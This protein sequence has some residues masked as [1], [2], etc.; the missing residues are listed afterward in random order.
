MPLRTLLVEPCESFHT[1]VKDMNRLLRRTVTLDKAVFVISLDTELAWGSFDRNG[2]EKYALYYA[3]VR[4]IVGKLL[5]MFEQ[6]QVKATWALVGHLFL[7]SCS[8]EGPDNH[9]HVLQPNYRWYPQG[10]LSHDPY[11]TVG[12]DPFFYAPDLADRIASALPRHELASHTFTH[13]ILGDPECSREVAFSQLQE[14]KRLAHAKG[15]E[16]LSLVFPRNRV[17]HL[18]V[19]CQLGFTS[20]RGPEK[21]W[22][23]W[24]TGTSPIGKALR[25]LN[26][27]LVVSPPCYQE[28]VCYREDVGQEWLVNL[29]GSMFFPPYSGL[30]RLVGISKRISQAKKGIDMAIRRKALF[31]LWFHP[32]NLASSP[33]LPPAL[34][35]ILAYVA[36][37]VKAGNIEAL[38]MA[39]TARHV[40]SCRERS[41]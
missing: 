22:Y 16:T 18:D 9:N 35:E 21:T 29:P 14:C 39:E 26:K 4:D 25:F 30:W 8:R 34:E 27:F 15:R 1:Q 2:V 12:A 13:A 37:H 28:F 6:H 7:T 11:S 10:W 5:D 31:H 20:F 19:L 32:F 40:T 41:D 36:R 33:L 3:Q 38:T 23:G 17:G 24:T